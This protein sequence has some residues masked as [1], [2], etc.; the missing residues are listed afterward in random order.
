MGYTHHQRADL[1]AWLDTQGIDNT[2]V[3]LLDAL[4]ALFISLIREE[5]S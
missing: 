4:L 5:E 1:K 2:S 3:V